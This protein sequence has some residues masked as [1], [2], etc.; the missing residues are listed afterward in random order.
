MQFGRVAYLKV[1]CGNAADFSVAVVYLQKRLSPIGEVM[2]CTANFRRLI[3]QVQTEDPG[4]LPVN[5]VKS[6]YF[7]IKHGQFRRGI[8]EYDLA[9]SLVEAGHCGSSVRAFSQNPRLA[10]Q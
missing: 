3:H 10:R 1:V 2:D 6:R 5:P 8:E 4:N 7:L 9:F